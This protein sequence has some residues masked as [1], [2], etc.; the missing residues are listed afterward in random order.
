MTE[1]LGADVDALYR[2]AG[3]FGG[4]SRD[5]DRI[6][7]TLRSHVHSVH[8]D[9]PDAQA[10][11]AE[12]DHRWVPLLAAAAQALA[13][14]QKSLES[15]ASQQLDASGE[16][17]QASP[18]WLERVNR[19][20]ADR[21][22]D[23][24]DRWSTFSDFAHPMLG[25]VT[26]PIAMM[27]IAGMLV[28]KA[29]TIGRYSKGWATAI[30]RHGDLLRY[31]S[32]P[33]L[34]A[35]A[36]SPTL[37]FMAKVGSSGLVKTVGKAAGVVGRILSFGDVV[38]D[39]AHHRYAASAEKVVDLGASSL[40]GSKNPVAYLAGVNVS[41]WTE[42]GRELSHQRLEDWTTPLPNPFSGKAM[43]EVY[44]PAAS[45]TAVSLAKLAPEILL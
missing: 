43:R 28:S 18:G 25:L 30:A 35:V 5:L 26:Q 21:G 4:S 12:C 13:D 37:A 9:G 24:S 41:L 20:L 8:W 39:V 16:R 31:K 11:R 27:A 45:E 3:A 19:W 44:L 1:R 7:A 33:F 42:V 29:N 14:G 6:R 40:K 36:G 15:Q 22:A 34:H 17:Q 32:S 10:I 23:L 2:L 38:N